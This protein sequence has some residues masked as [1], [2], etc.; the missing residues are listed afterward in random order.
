MDSYIL[1]SSALGKSN[2]ECEENEEAEE[3]SWIEWF[4][5]LEGN[6]FLVE[7]DESFLREP[8]N[9]YGLKSKINSYHFK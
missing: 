8:L 4:C 9:S 6:E 2:S 3:I 1:G 5:S 7:I